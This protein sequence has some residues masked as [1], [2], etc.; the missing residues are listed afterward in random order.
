MSANEISQE[1]REQEQLV[2]EWLLATPGFFERHGDLLAKVQ[3][4]SPHGDKA[5]SLQERQMAVLRD[6]NKDLNRRLSEMLR[7]GAE[8][9]R[10]QNLMVAWLADLLAVTEYDRAVEI[11][12]TGL[13]QIFDVGTVQFVSAASFDQASLQAIKEAPYCGA[14]ANVSA[15]IKEHLPDDAQSLAALLL[16]TPHKDLGILL[17]SSKQADR[18]TEQMGLVYLRQLSQLA[19]S[20]LGRFES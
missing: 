16:S 17:L 2:A 20:A 7:F 4:K 15:S 13:N 14:I 10:T 3:L 19:A 18:F 9:D 6:Q 11:M 8:N 12:T 1:Q 5:I